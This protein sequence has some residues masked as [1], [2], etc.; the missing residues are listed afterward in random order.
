MDVQV[1]YL[2]VLLAAL[3]SMVVG[4]VWYAKPVFGTDWQKLVKLSDK[5]MKAWAPFALVVAFTSSL[6]MAYV[7]AHVAF[8]S[9]NFY[10]NSF[11]QDALTTG[12]WIW[13]GFQG[14]RLFMHD[15]FER[16]RKKLSIINAG[17]ELATIMLMAL[18]IGLM[19][20]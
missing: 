20:P 16:R 13:L 5:D 3:S 6:V 2:A 9:N 4:M 19:K 18:I 1:N 17:N 15:Q 12:L 7:L 8:L 14:L 10:H 11:L